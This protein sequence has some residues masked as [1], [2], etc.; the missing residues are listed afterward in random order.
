MILGGGQKLSTGK[1]TECLA[2]MAHAS[3]VPKLA[4]NLVRKEGEGAY[5][6][7]VTSC[8]EALIGLLT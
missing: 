2:D 6:H 4:T 5:I 3:P 8:L 7:T 1:L